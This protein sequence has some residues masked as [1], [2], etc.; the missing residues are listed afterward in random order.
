MHGMYEA[1]IYSEDIPGTWDYLFKQLSEKVGHDKV[2]HAK[3]PDL[4]G[5]CSDNATT[6]E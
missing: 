5:D 1:R 4:C 2:D 3:Y 6:Q